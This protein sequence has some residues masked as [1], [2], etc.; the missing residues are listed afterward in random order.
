MSLNIIIAHNDYGRFSGEEVAVQAMGSVLKSNGHTVTWVRPSSGEIG[1]SFGK[2]IEAFF[3]GIYNPGSRRRIAKLLRDQEIDLVQ[4][5]NLYPFLSPSILLACKEED[6]PVVMRCPNYRLFCP[7]G[8]HLH[9]GRICERCL[10]GKEWFCIL[11]NCEQSRIKSVGYAARN[12]FARKTGMILDNVDVFV[13]L[14]RFQKE[15]FVAHGIPVEKIEILHNMAPVVEMSES[16]VQPGDIISFV[17]RICAEKGIMD[18]VDAARMLPQYS[19]A[20]AGSTEAMPG[21]ESRAPENLTFFGF[22]AGKKLDEFFEKSRMLVF[23]STWFEG[24]PNVIA[25]AMAHGKPVIASRIGAIPEIVDDCETGLLFE[26]GNARDMAQKI[27]Y[28]WQRAELCM[29]M[30]RKGIRKAKEEYSE[31]RYYDRL[32]VIYAKALG[33]ARTV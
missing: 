13:V 6:V 11:L 17:G 4:V 31:Q 3:S 14:S 32:M 10:G 21:I 26:P 12:A 1:D 5:Q 23:P 28:L 22:L 27:E 30:G 9:E 20:A 15:R 33:A 18:L 8:L 7:N 16:S 19:F 25:K 29:E 2:K 24:F